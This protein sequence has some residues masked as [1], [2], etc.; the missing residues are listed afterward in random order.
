M[1]VFFMLTPQVYFDYSRPFSTKT[2][3]PCSTASVYS[4][5]VFVFDNG[6]R[7]KGMRQVVRTVNIAFRYL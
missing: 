5:L 3:Q 4:A 7:N 2:W 6:E 1:I